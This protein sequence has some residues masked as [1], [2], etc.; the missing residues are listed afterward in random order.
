MPPINWHNARAQAICEKLG[1]GYHRCATDRP[2]E[3]ALFDFL[4]SHS[5]RG[6]RVKRV[7]A[8]V[9]RHRH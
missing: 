1:A 2:L 5:Q 4:R 7:S 3:V 6:R 9:M 8:S